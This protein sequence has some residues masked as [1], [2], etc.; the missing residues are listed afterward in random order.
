LI[1]EVIVSLKRL[2]I[3]R[4]FE[5]AKKHAMKFTIFFRTQDGDSAVL[6]RELKMATP[7]L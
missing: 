7:P 3:S 2:N 6:I 4:N 1:A 5:T